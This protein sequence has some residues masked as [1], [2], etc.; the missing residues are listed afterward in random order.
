M[1]NTNALAALALA[2]TS[3]AALADGHAG[4]T[5]EQMTA[6]QGAWGEGTVNIGAIHA[7]NG[8]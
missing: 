7:A 2:A 8:D 1:T 4:L 6:L 3:G 5:L